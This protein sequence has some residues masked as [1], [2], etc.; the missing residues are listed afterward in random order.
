MK[1]RIRRKVGDVFQISLPNGRY[2]YGRIYRDASVGIY[3][4]ITDEPR[5]PPIGSRDFMFHVGMYDDII[6]SGEFPIVGRDP[7]ENSESEWPP[8]NFIKDQISGEYSVYHKG[9]IRKAS[10]SECK[11]LEE[12]AVW[13]SHH[14]VDR[15]MH[16]S[17]HGS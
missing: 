6:K 10:E 7:F 15:I 8:P 13:D 1:K 2:A 14:I 12:A 11:G 3:R 9:E 17:D 16:N 4:K 5:N